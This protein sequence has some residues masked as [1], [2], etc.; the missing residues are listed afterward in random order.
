MKIILYFALIFI[1]LQEILH[2]VDLNGSC[3]SSFI[4]M[5][6]TNEEDPITK[7]S[8][9]SKICQPQP[10]S[11]SIYGDN[12]YITFTNKQIQ[13][14]NL[15]Y[16]QIRSFNTSEVILKLHYS[17]NQKI[18]FGITRREVLK[19]HS[20]G[21][22]EKVFQFEGEEAYVSSLFDETNQNLY[23][24]TERFDQYI[25]SIDKNFRYQKKIFDFIYKVLSLTMVD[26]KV[27]GILK[28]GTLG[29]NGWFLIDPNT[30]GV[31]LLGLIE[32]DIG[33]SIIGPV[34]DDKYFYFGFGNNQIYVGDR[35]YGLFEKIYKVRWSKKSE[36]LT[37]LFIL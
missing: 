21:T 35:V 32:N 37:S 30:A 24:V 18:L 1:T 20:N 19:V 22:T 4:S 34:V 33:E 15:Q 16:R 13:V 23:V 8:T 28:F 31:K 6:V 3:E 11:L 9:F 25:Y 17:I 29:R 5:N 26:R 14:Y 7:I 10:N 12:I 27:H 36:K 2:A